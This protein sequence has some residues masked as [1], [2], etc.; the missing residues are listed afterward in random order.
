MPSTT[1]TPASWAVIET[2][3]DAA[4]EQA[5]EPGF[6]FSTSTRTHSGPRESHNPT[7]AR[8]ATAPA[9]RARSHVR[10]DGPCHS[11]AAK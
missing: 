8:R 9:A 6:A 2:E 5:C 10:R 1:R 4:L 3:S 11:S 7:G